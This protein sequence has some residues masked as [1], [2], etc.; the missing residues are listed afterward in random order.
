MKILRKIK[1]VLL[2]ILYN[3]PRFLFINF[4]RLCIVRIN[5]INKKEI[6]GKNSAIF[7][8]NHTTGAD[9]IIVLG[10]LRKKIYF[11][12]DSDRFKTKFTDFFF[13]KFTNSIPVFK[14]EF[15]KNI[16]SFRELFLIAKEKKIFFGIFPEG[17][18]NKNNMFGKFHN[19]AAYLSY[20]TKLPIIPVYI[21]NIHKGPAPD[22]KFGKNPVMEGIY[23]LFSNTFRKIHVFIGEPIDPVAENIFTDFMEMADKNSYKIIL[24]RITSRLENEFVKLKN[25]A[26]GLIGTKENFYSERTTGSSE[27]LE[28]YRISLGSSNIGLIDDDIEEENLAPGSA[29]NIN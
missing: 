20:K 26:D 29:G 7:T 1:E 5:V 4:Y 12:A 19:G 2:N 25:E 21:H 8:F 14:K 27:V 6:A 17:S 11:I 28:N 3:T 13:R 16:N 24:N 18:L 9:P 22:S 15:L 10:A 23:S